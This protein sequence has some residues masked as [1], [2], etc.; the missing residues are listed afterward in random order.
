MTAPNESKS[1]PASALEVMSKPQAKPRPW[2]QDVISAVTAPPT[3]RK[4]N[5]LACSSAVGK[6]WLVKH[7]R[8]H[9]PHAVEKAVMA[10]TCSRVGILQRTTPYDACVAHHRVDRVQRQ[11]AEGNL[12]ILFASVS[13][14]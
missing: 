5:W 6:T 10:H 12:R 3:E 8:L 4:V 7:L 13:L 1:K 9:V 2:Q 11:A 14:C